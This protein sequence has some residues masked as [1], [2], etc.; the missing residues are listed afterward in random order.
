MRIAST[1][2]VTSQ[3]GLHK[4]LSQKTTLW[5]RLGWFKKKLK[6]V[7]CV[8]QGPGS[9]PSVLCLDPWEQ[10][11]YPTL[12][13]GWGGLAGAVVGICLHLVSPVG[14]VEAGTHPSCSGIAGTRKCKL[15]LLSFHMGRPVKGASG[16]SVSSYLV[17]L[18]WGILK[19][20]CI[21]PS[22]FPICQQ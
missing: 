18:P 20:C 16:Q 21:L 13:L 11:R 15:P 22:L 1:E 6:P 7:F 12:T 3:P 17:V 4:T 8:G 10:L 19:R 5:K 14:G 2:G 9:K